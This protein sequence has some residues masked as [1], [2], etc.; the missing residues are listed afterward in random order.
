[1]MMK[2]ACWGIVAS[3]LLVSGCTE[4]RQ[5]DESFLEP[6]EW[7]KTE[8]RLLGLTTDGALAFKTSVLEDTVK[9][10]NFYLD[11]YEDGA[12]NEDTSQQLGGFSYNVEAPFT[13]EELFFAY[14]FTQLDE[15]DDVSISFFVQANGSGSYKTSASIPYSASIFK[16][17][18]PAD[19]LDT[20]AEST[21]LFLWTTDDRASSNWNTE[22]GMEELRSRGKTFAMIRVEWVKE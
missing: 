11:V 16:G 19:R 3:L 8:D 7:N 18:L 20:T 22:E 13:D 15:D 9:E 10:M 2:T 4:Q 21:P 5:Q 12:L 14:Q 1:M 6:I 17:Y